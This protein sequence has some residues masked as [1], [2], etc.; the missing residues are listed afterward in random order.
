MDISIYVCRHMYD[1]YIVYV[2]W[3]GC[4]WQQL[5]DGDDFCER[6]ASKREVTDWDLW[7]VGGVLPLWPEI[8]RFYSEHHLGLRGQPAWPH[9]FLCLGLRLG[10]RTWHC[11]F[12]ERRGPSTRVSRPGMGRVHCTLTMQGQSAQVHGLCI[13]VDLCIF[14]VPCTDRMLIN[15][16]FAV[17]RLQLAQ[18]AGCGETFVIKFCLFNPDKFHATV[19]AITG[20][21]SLPVRSIHSQ[22]AWASTS[23]CHVLAQCA[24]IPEQPLRKRRTN[25]LCMQC[26]C[27]GSRTRPSSFL[28]SMS[29][30]LP[31]RTAQRK[32]LGTYLC[33]WHDCMRA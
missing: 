31:T 20:R 26:V 30:D 16:S 12:C 6:D 27:W 29:A 3:H 9:V 2:C 17:H 10:V 18:D 4:A 19:C 8:G 5:L 32:I 11:H 13:H 23:A 22:N 33:A 14:Y 28:V 1:R 25:A 7:P 24:C 15:V 21:I